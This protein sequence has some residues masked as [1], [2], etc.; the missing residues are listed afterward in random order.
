[1]EARYG[2]PGCVMT[3]HRETGQDEVYSPYLQGHAAQQHP[4]VRGEGGGVKQ[5][6]EHVEGQGGQGAGN[7]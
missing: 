1:M 6:L 3:E 5:G 7:G 2:L 4:V